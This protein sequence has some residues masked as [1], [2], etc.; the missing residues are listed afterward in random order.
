MITADRGSPRRGC[1]WEAPCRRRLR[2]VAYASWEPVT[3]TVTNVAATIRFTS[4]WTRA[5]HRREAARQQSIPGGH[6]PHHHGGAQ[7]DDA[8]AHVAGD[9]LGPRQGLLKDERKITCV[10][11]VI[12][13]TTRRIRTNTSAPSSPLRPA[14]A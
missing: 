8:D 5:A 12:T 6:P 2:H 7:P 10:K 3:A 1:P 9:L 13:M 4:N 14:F 11:T